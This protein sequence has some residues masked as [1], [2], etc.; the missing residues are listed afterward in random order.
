MS[1]LDVRRPVR[2]S[3]VLL[4]AVCVFTFL[5]AVWGLGELLRHPQRDTG[6]APDDERLAIADPRQEVVCDV[7]VP[8]E[9]RREAPGGGDQT[10]IAV[11]SADLYDCPQVYDGRRV[12]YRGE[13]VGALLYRDDGVW[14]Q[15]N[16][17]VYAELVGPLPTH[18]HYSGINAG[19]G[20]LLPP[21]A[22]AEVTSVGGPQTRGDV[23]EITGTFHRV[24]ATSEVAII[25]AEGL[26]VVTRGGRYTDPPLPGRRVAA[27]VMTVLAAVI[28]GVERVVARRR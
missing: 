2:R 24:D 9:G 17:D 5:A 13:V 26:R 12:R 11:G 22:A 3:R 28:A 8:R 18:R 1:G 23:V 7:P 27:A 14:T 19:V 21:A 20:V 25:R 15:I 16:D 4:G 10:P 6:V